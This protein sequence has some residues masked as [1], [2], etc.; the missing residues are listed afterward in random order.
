[1]GKVGKALGVLIALA[2]LVVLFVVPTMF[3]ANTWLAWSAFWGYVDAVS[4]LTGINQYLL[5]ALALM[6][7]VPYY[8]GT[9]MLFSFRGLVSRRRRYT[10]AAILLAMA[11]GYNLSLYYVTKEMAF[12]FSGGAAQK[13]YA[14]TPEGVKYY[15]RSGFDTTYGIS[16]Q[17]VT[18]ELMPKL[19]LLEKGEYKPIDP[20]QKPLF[21][22]ITGQPLAWYYQYPEGRFEFYDTPGYHPL[23]GTLL[24]PVTQEVYFEW[25]KT[26]KI[27]SPEIVVKEPSPPTEP[28]PVKSPGTTTAAPPPRPATEAP[29]VK[30]PETTSMAALPRRGIYPVGREFYV[31][32][33]QGLGKVHL[34]NIEIVEGRLLRFNF[35][36]NWKQ[37][38]TPGHIARVCESRSS[39]TVCFD[40]YIAH[41]H[42]EK[43]VPSGP[44]HVYLDNPV[45][46]TFLVD[47]L[48]RQHPLVQ[49]TGIG[50]DRP[51]RVSPDGS[52]RFTLTFP[53]P[54]ET[55]YFKYQA[56]L[57]IRIGDKQSHLHI[58]AEENI[59][60]TDF[61]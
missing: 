18:P 48:G 20:T 4:N 47:N 35:D 27:Q 3:V 7:L 45:D 5:T 38:W 13:W 28:T 51:I 37:G 6:M 43:E 53:F 23:T 21:N 61:R 12:A 24:K 41:P 26:T 1:M 15:S 2:L 42:P 31:W 44:L 60:L 56:I 19:K 57:L 36:F 39:G 32:A 29:S 52:K 49:A 30:S 10:G 33:G 59:N 17:P 46:T 22:P 11:V 9:D 55:E 40:R 54:S 14:L 16:L 25:R 58:Q 50:A 8:I 34:F